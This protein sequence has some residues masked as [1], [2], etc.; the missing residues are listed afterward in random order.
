MKL[1]QIHWILT[2]LLLVLVVWLLAGRECCA[3]DLEEEEQHE[4]ELAVYMGRMQLFADKLWWAGQAQN[5]ELVHFYLHEMEEAM[6]EVEEAGLVE[7]GVPLSELMR[8]YGLLALETMKQ[9]PMDSASFTNG[10]QDLISSCNG[11]H[12]SANHAYIKLTIPAVPAF[13]GQDFS[14]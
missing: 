3:P 4:V 11:C 10:Y 14:Q 2:I 9:V 6:E 7:D 12:V 8:T 1:Q 13:S 5:E